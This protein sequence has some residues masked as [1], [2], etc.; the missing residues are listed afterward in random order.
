MN[1]LRGVLTV[2]A[3][4][5][6]GVI[7]GPTPIFAQ[8]TAEEV[9]QAALYQEEVQG[10]LEQA[11]E[12]FELI[13]EDFAGNRPVA[14]K[15]LMHIGL[16]HEKL[17]SRGAQRAYQR[18]VREYADQILVADRARVRLAS[19]Q[20]LARVEA[21]VEPASSRGMV[22]RHLFGGHY[23]DD[24]DTT[25]E[26]SPDGRY[27]V[28]VDWGTTASNIAVRDL[29][30]G[31]TRQLT[32][33]PDYGTGMTL[34][35]S[36]SPDGNTIAYWWLNADEETAEVRLA[37]RDGSPP[38]TLCA[39]P[40]YFYVP[41]PWRK[42]GRSLVVSREG[43]EAL[44]EWGWVSPSDGVFQ[45]FAAVPDGEP[46]RGRLS[47]SPDDRY[48][49]FDVGMAPDSDRRDI[50]MIPIAGGPEIGIVQ[51]P[52]NDRIIGWV[53]GTDDFLF[54]S[55]R[56]GKW[57]LYS[58]EVADGEVR[59]N[60][61]IVQRDVGPMGPMGFTQDGDLYF[62]I[63]TLR[64]FISV[65]PFD[66][67]TGSV[68]AETAQPLLGPKAYPDW[69]PD[70]R[71]LTYWHK[72]DRPTNASDWDQVLGITDLSTG[73]ERELAAGL[74]VAAPRWSLDGQSIMAMA[75]EPDQE[76]NQTP[77]FYS[78]DPQTGD[79]RELLRFPPQ[80]NWYWEIGAAQAPNGRDLVYVRG[81]RL[82]L[83]EAASGEETELYRH[84]GLTSGILEPSPDGRTLLFAVQDSTWSGLQLG[85]VSGLQ[86]GRGRIML[87]RLP[88]GE[89][90]EL[91][92]VDLEQGGKIE[93]IVWGP[94]GRY[95]YFAQ[96]GGDEGTALKR[97]PINGG[98]PE[99]V[100]VFREPM[101]RF[102]ISP[103]GDRIAYTSG[104]NTR[105]TYVMENLRAALKEMRDKR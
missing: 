91:M 38:Q 79:V 102:T 83:H 9:Y 94:E 75:M 6:L 47:L 87:A 84:G 5:A 31:E 58:V 27:L 53:P 103:T 98:D 23:G 96:T 22:V 11:I 2:V 33:H 64:M 68:I 40:G 104:E 3:L 13:L 63:Y 12:L 81:G 8:E 86:G 61:G 36:L 55:D 54:V 41:G 82:V 17:G 24:L 18:L 69:S 39:D 30:T 70:G 71:Y 34:G 90:E 77:G 44:L 20:G 101:L 66:P 35:A 37:F 25:G 28:G 65:A 73:E 62:G 88:G 99:V 19:L 50:Y 29:V 32:D 76:G 59:G 4:S 45:E 43:Q 93:S 52:A 26:P 57:D 7:L 10:D 1:V 48:L 67:E 89:I 92:A 80:R 21:P 42:D 72:R 85:T 105:D 100:W 49:A 78:I 46:E 60:P 97:V 15:A 56:G 74:E 16:C 14:A 95:V 51:H